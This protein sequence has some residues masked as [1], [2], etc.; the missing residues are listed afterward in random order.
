MQSYEEITA[1]GPVKAASVPI[2]VRICA[3]FLLAGPVVGLATLGAFAVQSGLNGPVV[4]TS[5]LGLLAGLPFLLS[6]AWLWR[7]ERRGRNLSIA[8]FALQLPLLA[9]KP[10]AYLL[11]SGLGLHFGLT[12]DRSIFFEFELG[13]RFNVLVGTGP[14][15]WLVGVNLVALACLIVLFR[16]ARRR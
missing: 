4:L 7:G 2:A 8:L 6:G 14:E 13:A 12:A 9:T 1:A 3:V 5:V 15:Q 16:D 10:V 11:V